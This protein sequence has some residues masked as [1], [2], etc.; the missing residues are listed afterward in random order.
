MI[1]YEEFVMIHTLHRQAYS[2]RAIAKMTN[3][4]RRTVSK[5]LKEE[6][7]KPRKKVV[8]KSKLDPFKDYIKKRIEDALP[9]RI[10]STVILQEIADR[11]YRGKIR[12]LQ[13]YMSNI[14]KEILTDKQ[15]SK[16]IR[17]ETAMGKQAQVDWTTIRKGSNPIYAFVMIL[18]YSRYTYVC[19]TDNMRYETFEQCH[20]KA[21]EYFG[22]IPENIL[23]DNL[24]SVV[25]KRNAYGVKKHKFNERFLDFSKTY[26]FIPLLCKPYRAQTKGKVERFIGYM[27]RN[28]YIPLKSKLKY[29]HLY[30]DCD[31]LNTQIFRWLE[32]TNNRVH[33]TLKQKP[34][35]LFEQEKKALLPIIR[36][37]KPTKTSINYDIHIRMDKSIDLNKG[38]YLCRMI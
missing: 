10:P 38:A 33:A 29:S 3:L 7:L 19:F 8:Y 26:G 1:T 15:P 27:K 21:F 13:K 36:T 11:G 4:N 24:K 28:F 34:K 2:I 14:Y 9:H 20:I 5:R 23:Y 22:G 25:V 6:E 35:E 18:G 12:I 30:I 17:F 32:I 31:L 37:A 16:T